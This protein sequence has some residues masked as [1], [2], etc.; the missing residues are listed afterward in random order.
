MQ[1]LL[2]FLPT[3]VLWAADR[4]TKVWA[5]SHLP[6]AV[7]QPLIGNAIRLT[8]VRNTGGVFG[9]LPGNSAAFI[10]A[11]AVVSVALV[12]LLL[13]RRVRGAWL[14]AGLSVI[15]AGAIGNLIDRAVYGYVIDFFEIRGFPIFNLADS[16]ITVGALLVIVVV[17]WGGDRHRS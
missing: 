1:R 17:L 9:L 8:Y 6:L 7:P 16:C 15:L 4:L 3:V 11:S 5:V 10:A 13:L 2:W 14:R 12:V